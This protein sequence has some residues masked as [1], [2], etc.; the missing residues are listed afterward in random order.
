MLHTR[1]LGMELDATIKT[2]INHAL[3]NALQGIKS[4]TLSKEAVMEL[5]T[6][7][8]LPLLRNSHFHGFNI[9]RHFHGFNFSRSVMHYRSCHPPAGNQ[10]TARAISYSNYPP[11]AFYIP[12]RM[13]SR[14]DVASR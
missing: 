12:A 4:A 2:Q 1:F 5:L 6:A 10:V 13:G 7:G 14:V 8:Q 3:A 11:S 9:S